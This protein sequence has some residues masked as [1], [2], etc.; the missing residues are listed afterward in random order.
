[1]SRKGGAFTG[2][3]FIYGG[4]IWGETARPACVLRAKRGYL[5]L[6]FAASIQWSVSPIDLSSAAAPAAVIRCLHSQVRSR[7][8]RDR[9]HVRVVRIAGQVRWVAAASEHRSR[10]IAREFRPGTSL[11][12]ERPVGGL[13]LPSAT[14][15]GPSAPSLPKGIASAHHSTRISTMTIPN[16]RRPESPSSTDKPISRL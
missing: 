7:P 1:M 9:S 4:E 6:A 14:T 8:A 5:P 3:R 15:A 16:H 2:V 12:V 10:A 13:A 11:S